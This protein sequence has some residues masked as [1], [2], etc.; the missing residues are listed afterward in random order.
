MIIINLFLNNDEWGQQE[1]KNQSDVGPL[2]SRSRW[3]ILPNILNYSLELVRGEDDYPAPGRHLQPVTP[4]AP[5]IV[6]RLP[7]HVV[8]DTQIRLVDYQFLLGV[9]EHHSLHH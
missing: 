3:K 6:L 4:V 1:I 5:H 7:R 9:G 2:R 8:I